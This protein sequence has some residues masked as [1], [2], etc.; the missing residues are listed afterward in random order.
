M[1]TPL[2][3]PSTAHRQ[4]TAMYQFAQLASQKSGQDLRQYHDLWHWSIN[5]HEAFWSL[6][7]DFFPIQ[8]HH[9]GEIVL[10]QSHQKQIH[11]EPRHENTPPL[12]TEHW[13]TDSRLNFAENLLAYR[14]EQIAI[15]FFNENGLQQQ[16][17]YA[18][19]YNRVNR[20]VQAL[21]KQGIR[22]NDRVVA[23]LPNVPQAI[24]AML[25]CTSLGA[26]WSSCSPD[27]GNQSLSDR[28]IQIQPKALIFANGYV[29]KGKIHNCQEKITTLIKHLP[30]LE[31]AIQ[32]NCIE[33]NSI[34]NNSIKSNEKKSTLSIA[35][36]NLFLWESLLKGSEYQDEIEFVSL[37]FNHPIY[38][39][40]S[41]G[42]TGVPKCIVHGAGGTLLQHWKELALHTDIKRGDKLFYYTSTGW[43]MWNWLVS[44]LALGCTIVLYDGC[45]TYPRQSILLEWV[46]QYQINVFGCSAKYISGLKQSGVD[47]SQELKLASLRSLLSTGSPLSATL[48]DYIMQAIKSPLQ[49]ASISGGTDIISCFALGN[50]LLPVFRG[51]LQAPGLGMAVAIYS[52]QGKPLQQQKGELVCTRSFPSMPIYFWNDP[53]QIKYGQAYFE[54]FKAVWTH[55]DYAQFTENGGLII[56]G[57]SDTTLNPGGI[58]IG[59]AEIYRCVEQFPQIVDSL[60]IGHDIEDDQQ[61]ILFVQ[62]ADNIALHATLIKR[63]KEK[64]RHSAS[65]HHVPHQ[66]IAVADIPRTYNG[67]LAEKAVYQMVHHQAVNNRSALINPDALDLF[68]NLKNLI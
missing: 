14:D 43:M 31:F 6:L 51:E 11:Q 34:K 12:L 8:F 40:F 67:K 15:E 62:L 38:I 5:Q 4:S 56:Y 24:I 61:I 48:F 29:Y 46:D 60:V 35:N 2:W 37:P 27:F 7:A 32:V 59:T 17:T 21:K 19:L 1:S 45:P 30:T 39:L 9:R 66:I 28:F 49:I 22:S 52:E 23:V 65:I 3:Q 10:E 64:I 63:L 47:V 68:A 58:R 42:T 13:F 53:Q 36:L 44:G 54:R 16:L 18:Q 25:A 33:S 26:I 55:G 41:S 57:R 20:L 50:P